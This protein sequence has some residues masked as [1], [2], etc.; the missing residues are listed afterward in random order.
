M[1]KPGLHVTWDHESLTAKCP[2][3]WRPEPSICREVSVRVRQ[4]HRGCPPISGDC[5]LGGY[6]A[7]FWRSGDAVVRHYRLEP[8]DHS[9]LRRNRHS[10]ASSPLGPA[11]AKP[12]NRSSSSPRVSSSPV[13][14]AFPTLTAASTCGGWSLA[15]IRGWV[16]DDSPAVASKKL[17][18]RSDLAP[19]SSGKEN[20]LTM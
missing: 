19:R 3:I 1:E 7:P 4:V 16:E 8:F 11:G 9:A 10:H 5:E 2:S 17:G 14:I 12:R 15:R 18:T 20:H 6:R 13:P